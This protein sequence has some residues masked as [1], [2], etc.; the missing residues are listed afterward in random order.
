[1]TYMD[2]K[3]PIS[4]WDEDK[5]GSL[6]I[7]DGDDLCRVPRAIIEA[8]ENW[9]TEEECLREL[10]T[11]EEKQCPKCGRIGSLHLQH[12][13]SHFVCACGRYQVSPRTR[14][15]FERSRLSLRKWFFVIFL[16]CLQVRLTSVV[17]IKELGI[18]RRTAIRVLHVLAS[19]KYLNPLSQ[20]PRGHNSGSY[21]RFRNTLYVRF[22]RVIAE[23]RTDRGPAPRKRKR[24]EPPTAKLRAAAIRDCSEA[25][26]T[27][28]SARQ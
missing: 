15:P 12:G 5:H 3:T 19:C 22:H 25:E 20:P 23:I 28:G 4:W 11:D 26:A 27:G 16:D 17:L 9:M 18:A 13:R 10:V 1:M 8:R 7:V 6:R 2:D 21:Y 14:T 24:K